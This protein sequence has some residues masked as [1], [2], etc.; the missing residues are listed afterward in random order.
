MMKNWTKSKLD[1]VTTKIIFERKGCWKVE[2][3]LLNL[4]YEIWLVIIVIYRK[5]IVEVIS[6]G[7]GP[8]RD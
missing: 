6:D 5:K 8:L 3:L 4:R 1:T 7:K 2:L